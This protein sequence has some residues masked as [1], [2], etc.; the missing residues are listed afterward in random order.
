MAPTL[1]L[2]KRDL[3]LFLQQLQANPTDIRCWPAALRFELVRGGLIDIALY[4]R[5]IVSVP[6]FALMAVSSTSLA[7][8]S[9]K[10]D[11]P[12]INFTFD[13]STTRTLTSSGQ[14]KL[15]SG[16]E[17]MSDAQIRFHEVALIAF[18]KWLTALCTPRT[19]VLE[20]S[21][22]P[23]EVCIRFICV[24][25]LGMPEYVR[26][27]TNKFITL[28]GK[29]TLSSLELGELIKSCRGGDDKLLV[30]LAAKLVEKVFNEQINRKQLD[31]FL[32]TQGNHNLKE[33]IKQLEG[34]MGIK[35]TANTKPVNDIASSRK[36]RR[37]RRYLGIEKR[38][39][40]ADGWQGFSWAKSEASPSKRQRITEVK[41]D[42]DCEMIEID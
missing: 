10:P 6:R 2:S 25:V 40:D 23:V 39:I 32:S 26:H 8:C 7:L 37:L 19:V 35:R 30:G 3:R 34:D 42:S 16:Q 20:D 31:L 14:T 4:G 22:F 9:K 11:V 41:N 12:A 24:N 5:R 29:L 17:E 33:R 28:A 18:A 21:S 27:L 13:L 36:N 1:H 38:D 15:G